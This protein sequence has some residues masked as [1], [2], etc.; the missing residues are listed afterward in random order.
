MP[1]PLY[2]PISCR[3]TYLPRAIEKG[4]VHMITYASFY[5]SKECHFDFIDLCL[6]AQ[7]YEI[8]SIVLPIINELMLGDQFIKLKWDSRPET[9]T[10]CCELRFKMHDVI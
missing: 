9:S 4:S 10:V 3:Y 6:I 7:V 8:S 2:Q 5:C 1:G